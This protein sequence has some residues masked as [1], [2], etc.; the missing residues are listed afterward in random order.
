M[1]WSILA[2]WTSLNYSFVQNDHY[3]ANNGEP[4][5]KKWDVVLKMPRLF[6]GPIPPLQ[7][8]AATV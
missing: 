2:Q 4:Q 5:G 8:W 6:F 1:D 3:V 7:V